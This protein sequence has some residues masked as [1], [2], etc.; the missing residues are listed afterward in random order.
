MRTPIVAGNWKMNKTVEESLEFIPD[1]LPGI[2]G[3]SGVEIV[4]CP[5]FTSLWPMHQALRGSTV[6]LGGQDMYWVE[7]GAFTG[8]VTPGLLLTTGCL[9]VILGHSERRAVFGETDEAVNRKTVSAL[10]TGLIPIICVGETLDERK[11]NAT[12]RIV[13]RQVRCAFEGVA[14]E[15][16]EKAVIAYEPV[17]AIGTGLTATPEQAQEIHAFIRSLL[18][19]LYDETVGENIRILYGGSVKEDNAQD[20]FSQTQIDG[21]LIGGASLD[22]GAFAAIIKVAVAV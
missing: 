1:L 4:L 22:P 17:W 11:G 7:S 3:V 8:E 6:A 10:N 20:L 16:A 9:Y 5:P 15:E 18:A 14:A 13:D 12:R 2:E 19:D 21:G